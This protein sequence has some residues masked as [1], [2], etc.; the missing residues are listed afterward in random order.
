MEKQ[1]T[2]E[3]FGKT[4]KQRYTQYKNLSD[5]DVAEKVLA[6]YPEYSSK[7]KDGGVSKT[8]SFTQRA[9]SVLSKA[10]ESIKRDISGK[11][12]IQKGESPITS[13]F[14]AAATVSSIPLK[15]GYEALPQTAREG[16]SKVGDVIGGGFSALTSKIGD[17]PQLQ[18]WV[19]KNPEAAKRL[20]EV[21]KTSSAAGEI[22]GNVLVAD[23]ATKLASAGVKAGANIAKQ[24][25]TKI[26]EVG[27]DV[28]NKTKDIFTKSKAKVGDQIIPIPKTV[29]TTLSRVDNETLG[30][31]INQA[32]KATIDQQNATPLELAGDKAVE[33]LNK[34]QDKLST[35]GKL[36][37]GA[38]G[39]FG[40]KNVGTIATKFRQSLESAFKNKN[41]IGGDKK[42]VSDIIARSKTLGNN[43]T[44]SRVDAFIDEVQDLIYAS[45]RDLTV[46]VTDSITSSIRKTLGELNSGLKSQLPKSYS[47]FN[48]KYANLVGTRDMLNKALGL[49]A[50]KG[51][52]LL[53]RVFSPTDSGTKKLFNDVLKETGINLTDEAVLAKFAMELFGDPRQAS[54]LEKLS[55][56]TQRGLIEKLVEVAGGTLGVDDYIRN[57]KIKKAGSLTK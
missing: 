6:K 16:L 40:E 47:G 31:Y 18:E 39:A 48:D 32:K 17:I 35:Y 41:L 33:A 56:P 46:P 27:T 10:G 21:L 5:L 26:S 51:G 25:G 45:S 38:I 54:I 49:E 43:P 53:K 7:I 34:I 36:K 29:K 55:I 11:D 3:E 23:Q 57:L 37:S 22:A 9:S 14:Q 15:L 2:K 42:L 44:A 28:I 8:S 52:S 13:G 1:L 50:D 12:V 20:E 4:I 19:T 30:K 24:T